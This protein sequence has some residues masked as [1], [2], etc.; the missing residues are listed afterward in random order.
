VHFTCVMPGV[1]RTELAAG[2]GLTGVKQITPEQVGEAVAGVIERPRFDLYVPREYG[3]L[4]RGLAPLPPRARG[5]VLRL[6][7]AEKVTATTTRADREG[8]EER[9]RRLTGTPPP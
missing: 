1:V 5:A 4:A 8:Y 2:T 6:V 7:G 9:I 3:L